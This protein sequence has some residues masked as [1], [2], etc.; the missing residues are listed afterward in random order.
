MGE[1]PTLIN[2]MGLSDI[3]LLLIPFLIIPILIISLGKGADIIIK[4]FDKVASGTLLIHDYKLFFLLYPYYLILSLLMSF[5]I[6]NSLLFEEFALS[7][8]EIALI[9]LSLAFLPRVIGFTAAREQTRAMLITILTPLLI[10]SLP[11]LFLGLKKEIIFPPVIVKYC[12]VGALIFSV[13]G[14]L[15]ILFA[16]RIKILV[17][18][19]EYREPDFL[20]DVYDKPYEQNW[21]GL[22]AAFNKS[23]IDYDQQR[24]IEGFTVGLKRAKDHNELLDT[25]RDIDYSKGA[26]WKLISI[27]Q[28]LAKDEDK[29]VRS[30]A[31]DALKGIRSG[32]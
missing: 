19:P 11:L 7:E 27:L 21:K 8:L 22:A 1:V 26:S 30:A 20:K 13:L 23:D 14:E 5:L 16:Q 29:Y 15:W 10:F 31:A 4:A 9:A 2:L 17:K 12:L 24:I 32:I 18:L 28:E 25:L 6:E 3:F